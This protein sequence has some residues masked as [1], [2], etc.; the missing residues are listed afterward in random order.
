MDSIGKTSITTSKTS[1]TNTEKVDLFNAQINNAR[2]DHSISPNRSHRSSNFGTENPF[3]DEVPYSYQERSI[4]EIKEFIQL[5]GA[6]NHGA[7][8]VSPSQESAHLLK[9]LDET[10]KM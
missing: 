6:V 3:E 2:S 5:N 10:G 4:N 9:K 1:S 8:S 7:S